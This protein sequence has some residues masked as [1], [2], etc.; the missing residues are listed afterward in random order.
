MLRARV[1]AVEERAK[2]MDT[3]LLSRD[4]AAIQP[5]PYRRSEGLPKPLTVASDEGLSVTRYPPLP[6]SPVGEEEKPA[7]NDTVS[8]VLT[9]KARSHAL[10]GLSSLDHAEDKVQVESRRP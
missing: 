1:V 5:L 3:P 2:M 10:V 4:G 9:F 6:D 7:C 8:T